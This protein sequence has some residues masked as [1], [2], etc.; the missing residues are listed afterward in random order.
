VI[1]YIEIPPLVLGD[2]ITIYPFSLLVITGVI[3]GTVVCHFRSGRAGI[4][5]GEVLAAVQWAVVGGFFFAH[6][7]AVLFY[8]PQLLEQEG[9]A[10]LWRFPAG[11]SS[12]GGL[13]GGYAFLML[14]LR[15]YRRPAL[16]MLDV[17]VEGLAVG[18]AFGRLGCAIA[19]DHPG[20]L[21]GFPLAVDYPGGPRHDLGLYDLALIVG[22]LLPVLHI[23]E[24]HRHRPG[25]KLVALCLVYGPVRFLLDFLRA[26][27]LPGSDPRYLGLTAGQYGSVILAVAGIWLLRRV[28]RQAPAGGWC[29]PSQAVSSAQGCDRLRNLTPRHETRS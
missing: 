22:V 4:S 26:T 29:S 7:V 2:S 28:L 25:V 8:K 10:V 16:P 3:V 9:L 14:H 21:T 24:R 11:L 13:F 12:I 17:I 6:L 19:H 15:W 23:V 1:P 27:D 5:S 18:W 20:I